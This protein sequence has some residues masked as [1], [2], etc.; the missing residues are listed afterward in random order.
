MARR[1]EFGE[2]NEVLGPIRG[3]MD[4]GKNPSLP[5]AAA[6]GA[7]PLDLKGELYQVR[8]PLRVRRIPHT[9][10]ACPTSSSRV[11]G[12]AHLKAHKSM[13]DALPVSCNR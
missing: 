11:R 12:S 4:N 9:P 8:R 6:V 10:Y 3:V 1:I 5:Y 7:V 13:Q 2:G